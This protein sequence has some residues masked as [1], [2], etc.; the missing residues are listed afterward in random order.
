MKKKTYRVQW[1]EA[2][3]YEH[4]YPDRTARVGRLSGEGLL[5]GVE[6]YAFEVYPTREKLLDAYYKHGQKCGNA[7]HVCLTPLV[8][9]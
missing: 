4:P 2:R 5:G 7:P 6:S 1:Q 3:S 9:P 8:R